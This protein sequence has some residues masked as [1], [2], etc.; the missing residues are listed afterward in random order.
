MEKNNYDIR[1]PMTRQLTLPGTDIRIRESGS[2]GEGSRAI[3]GYA[4]L[5]DTPSAPLYR[6]DEEEIRE[7]IDPGAVTQELL[8]ASDIKFTM[9][10]DR[11]ILLGRSNK[12]EGT[13]E[14]FI[15]EKG[16]GFNLD[17]PK[18]PNGDEALEMVRRGDISGCSFMFSTRYYD[19]DFVDRE[20]RN[21]GDLTLVTYRVKV[22]TGIHD[23][24]LAADP[25]YPDTSV[26]AREF[27][28]SL[29]G[30]KPEPQDAGEWKEQVAEMRARS[31]EKIY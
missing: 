2:D 25:A 27:Y 19:R 8:D 12:G 18:S 21:V 9:Y 6:D 23:F 20:V 24:T 7:V 11:Q 26:E 1:R 30:D 31:R 4:I 14:Y 3:T 10:H 17:L 16:V 28:L 22:I 13:L 5:F 15:D 29:R